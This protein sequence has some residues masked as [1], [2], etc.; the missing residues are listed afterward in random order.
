MIYSS[1][2]LG[3][4]LELSPA[5]IGC[6]LCLCEFPDYACSLYIAECLVQRKPGVNWSYDVTGCLILLMYSHREKPKGLLVI[7]L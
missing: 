2:L 5:V 6:M 4:F 3:C 7:A 1:L